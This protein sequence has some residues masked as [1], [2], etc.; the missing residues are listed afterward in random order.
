[1]IIIPNCTLP[2]TDGHHH[3]RLIHR[4]SAYASPVSSPTSAAGLSP[5][6]SDRRRHHHRQLAAPVSRSVASGAG[7]AQT[8]SQLPAR[9]FPHHSSHS[10]RTAFRRRRHAPRRFARQS[11]GWNCNGGHGASANNSSANATHFR[12]PCHVGRWPAS[13]DGW[14]IAAVAHPDARPDN[15][16][17]L[18]DDM[19]MR[20]YERLTKHPIL[21]P[22]KSFS[23]LPM[24]T[25]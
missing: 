3:A 21:T 4:T 1:M 2:H 14:S 20:S 7:A 16:G 5:P 9:L 15:H 19:L 12:R 8:R 10:F 24:R 11:I 22:L 23:I 18:G 6:P 13:A 25:L 17:L